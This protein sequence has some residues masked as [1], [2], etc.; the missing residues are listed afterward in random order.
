ME[1]AYLHASIDNFRT[2]LYRKTGVLSWITGHE[3]E[4]SG[5]AIIWYSNSGVAIQLWWVFCNTYLSVLMLPPNKISPTGGSKS[6]IGP[7]RNYHYVRFRC[8]GRHASIYRYMSNDL[9]CVELLRRLATELEL[10]WLQS[11]PWKAELRQDNANSTWSA[12]E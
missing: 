7:E 2:P 8:L 3:A 10:L 6:H 1:F 12:V 11:N 4:I 5:Q 9:R